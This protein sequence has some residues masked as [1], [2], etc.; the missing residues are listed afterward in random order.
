MR[1]LI[2]GATGFVGR[3]L[4]RVLVERGDFVAC[5]VRDPR[6]ESAR[7]L[8]AMGCELRPGDLTEDETL[9]AAVTEIDVVYYLAHLM[10]EVGEGELVEAEEQAA[11]SLAR[12]ARDAA[13]DRVVYLGGLG[14]DSVSEHLSARH[15][16]AEVLRED[17]PPLTYFR[18]AMIVGDE[19][20]SYVL[21]RSL[22]ERLPAMVSP[23]WLE[24]RTQPIGIEAVIEYLAQ[25]PLVAD[26]GD[27]EIELGGPEV[28]TYSEML[29]GMARALG[30]KVPARMPTP[31]GISAKAV[32]NVAG[33]VTRGS[34]REAEYLT[35]GLATDTIVTDPSGAELFEV[36]PE[37]YRLS[38]AR[39]IEAEARA[40][41]EEP[42]AP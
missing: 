8:A 25:A 16:T 4:A 26:A 29:E 36:E 6:S 9:E 2:V 42:A 12:A 39:A 13:V 18:A 37:D 22:V 11:R 3:G 19:S 21:L 5:F 20:G 35:A 24:N 28:M 33:A 15:R 34:P 14:D 10:S 40:E 32:G 38:L 1:V 30:E 7:E 17:G 27:R 23:E 31:R 41:A